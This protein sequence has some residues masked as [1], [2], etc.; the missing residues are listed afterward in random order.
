M[1]CSVNQSVVIAILESRVYNNDS[2]IT[3]KLIVC[4]L[5][6]LLSAYGH[7][8]ANSS[9]TV[10]LPWLAATG[11]LDGRQQ[12]QNPFKKTLYSYKLK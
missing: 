5:S 7:Y 6:D 11:N 3:Y 4:L 1:Y 2:V 12:Y 9:G 8:P 10:G